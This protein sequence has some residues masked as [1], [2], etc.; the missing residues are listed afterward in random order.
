M[1]QYV[2][3]IEGNGVA[4]AV[5]CNM[6]STGLDVYIG[7]EYPDGCLVPQSDDYSSKLGGTLLLSIREGKLMLEVWDEGGERQ[8]QE[9]ELPFKPIDIETGRPVE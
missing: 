3:T 2:G 4:I 1:S 8:Q 9:I 7:Q 5:A 6:G